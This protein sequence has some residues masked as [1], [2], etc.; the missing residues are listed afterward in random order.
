MTIRE[1]ASALALQEIVPPV[2]PERA[3]ASGYVGD[4]LSWVMGRAAPDS[5][6][7]TIMSNQNVAAVAVLADVS[8]VILA[9]GV[10][11]DPDLLNK[12][13]AQEVA[14]YSSEQSSYEIAGKLYALLAAM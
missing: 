12:A 5:A 10:S 11:P 3:V 6:W 9:E 14:L 7:I 4:L 2:D 13:R 1:T 8:L